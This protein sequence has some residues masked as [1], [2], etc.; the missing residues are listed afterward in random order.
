[1]S[2]ITARSIRLEGTQISNPN[3]EKEQSPFMDSADLVCGYDTS[4]TF[5]PEWFYTVLC[6]EK[7]NHSRWA[8][9]SMPSKR[10]E[11]SLNENWEI[12]QVVD[13][14]AYNQKSKG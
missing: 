6:R 13:T 14:K 12:I 1:M 3:P 2:N 9:V 10:W 7:T 4:I 5:Y 8:L 11:D